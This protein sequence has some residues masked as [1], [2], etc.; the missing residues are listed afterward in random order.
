ME[1][2]V[3]SQ[4]DKEDF[5]ATSALFLKEFEEKFVDYFACMY[6][7]YDKIVTKEESK[8]IAFSIYH[9]L[10]KSDYDI[11]EFRENLF[12]RMQYDRVM[13]GFLINRSVFYLIENY[14]SFSHEHEISS[15]VELLIGCISRFINIVE[16][17]VTPKV[18]NF[19]SALDVSF[20][21]DI[22]FSPTNNIIETFHQMKQENQSV[23]FLNLYKGVPISSEAT[24]LDIEGENVTFK[25][26]KLQEIA[27]K[28]DGQAFIVKNNHFSKHL[29]ADIVYNN[30]QANTVVLTNFIYLLNMPALQREFIRVHPDIVA[31]VFLHQFG[32]LQTSGRLYDLS[33]NGL[34][35][36]SSENNGMFVGAKVLI[37]F[38]LNSASV[39]ADRDRKI[40]VQGEVINIIE[41]KDSY[42]YCMRI[43]PDRA[44]SQKILHYITKREHE[45]LEDLNNELKEYVE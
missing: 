38:E 39:A 36:V 15:Q 20:S 11:S 29:K 24:I 26:D 6:V 8:E 12:D 43:F 2:E 5:L 45:I 23:I 16:D 40:E 42:R 7:N 14:I 4:S 34:G 32:N 35:V 27:M 22:M 21:N 17:E 10:F 25:I 28:L 33:M 3:I 13:I 9:A 31:K 44:M 19:T 18:C 1:N 30:F 37:E 41:Y